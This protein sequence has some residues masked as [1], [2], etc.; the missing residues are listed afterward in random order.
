MRYA[1]FQLPD[2]L[3]LILILLISRHFL[4]ISESA[5]FVI[6]GFWI[7]KDI[8]LYPFVGRYYDPDYQKDRFSLVG[9]KGTVKKPLKPKGKILIKGELWKAEVLDKDIAVNIDETVVVHEIK[10]LKLLVM[11]ANSQK[12]Q[13]N[14]TI[15]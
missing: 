5:I 15:T 4:K 7:L 10:G 13:T 2:L 3:I 12:T 1:L 6:I 11:P 9:K 14:D 8:A